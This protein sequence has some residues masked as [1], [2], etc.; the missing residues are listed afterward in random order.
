MR[1][2]EKAKNAQA[3]QVGMDNVRRKVNPDDH[4]YPI[5]MERPHQ[6]SANTSCYHRAFRLPTLNTVDL[7]YVHSTTMLVCSIENDNN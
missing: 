5:V 6:E 2:E 4:T 1:F 7:S 3:V